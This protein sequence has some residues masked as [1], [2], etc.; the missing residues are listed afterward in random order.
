MV[1]DCEESPMVTPPV[2]FPFSVIALLVSSPAAVMTGALPEDVG[3]SSIPL[4]CSTPMTSA[5]P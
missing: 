1:T 5:P 2:P 4:S 3:L